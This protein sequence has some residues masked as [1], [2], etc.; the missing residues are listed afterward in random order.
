MA[1]LVGADPPACI[2]LEGEA[3]G[4]GVEVEGPGDAALVEKSDSAPSGVALVGATAIVKLACEELVVGFSL[5]VQR[6]ELDQVFAADAELAPPLQP[7]MAAAVS[8][9]ETRA[10]RYI[11][12][13]CC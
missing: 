12:P 11:F 3:A 2:G 7:I 5:A 8:T 1:G 13:S 9:I 6:A 10:E 4:D